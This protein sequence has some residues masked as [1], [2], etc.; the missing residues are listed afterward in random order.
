MERK[1][2]RKEK[3]CASTLSSFRQFSSAPNNQLAV[4]LPSPFPPAPGNQRT[5]FLSLEMCLFRTFHI[6]RIIGYLTFGVWFL[7]LSTI[8]SEFTHVGACIRTAFLFTAQ[9]YSVVGMSRILFYPFIKWQTSVQAWFWYTLKSL[10]SVTNMY[11]GKDCPGLFWT[12]SRISHHF[13]KIILAIGTW[14][15]DLSQQ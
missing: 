6:N 5:S 2:T 10:R 8:F 11:M 12:W 15:V 7:W 4:T 1:G 14:I 9:W 3:G 13:G